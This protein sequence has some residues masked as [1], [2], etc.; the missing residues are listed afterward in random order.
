MQII[1][2]PVFCVVI[3]IID[4]AL[5]GLTDRA[6]RLSDVLLDASGVL[7]GFFIVLIIY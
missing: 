4:E 3:S 2:A 6:P 7:C 5:Q 1:C